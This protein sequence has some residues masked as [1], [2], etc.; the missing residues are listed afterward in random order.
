M[1]DPAQSDAPAGGD[2]YTS[3][4]IQVLEGLDL[5]VG[6]RGFDL[7]H[8]FDKLVLFDSDVASGGDEDI[9]A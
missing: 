3:E 2:A 7:G 5:G 4:S 6:G 8:A 1:T 9:I